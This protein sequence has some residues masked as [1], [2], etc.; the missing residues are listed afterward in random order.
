[1]IFL[2]ATVPMLK[3]ALEVMKAWGFDYRSHAVWYKEV[4]G[5]GFY[6]RNMHELLLLGR[7]GDGLGAPVPENRPGS[8]I[9]EKRGKHSEKPVI[10]YEI[11]E[12]MY[13]NQKYLEMFARRIRDG[14]SSWGD[15]TGQ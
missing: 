11:I 10:F 7:R 6:F 1:M 14:W 15:K 8:V 3:Q 13:P 12:R 4:M 5:T 2:W 9:V